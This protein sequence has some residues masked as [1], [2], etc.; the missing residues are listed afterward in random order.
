MFLNL[1]KIVTYS[2]ITTTTP[3]WVRLQEAVLVTARHSFPNTALLPVALMR[4]VTRKATRTAPTGTLVT[5]WFV[6]SDHC[7]H[8]PYNH[9]PYNHYPYNHHPC[10]H[11]L[12]NH[13]P[14]NYHP[15]NH[16][17]C[18]HYPYYIFC[19]LQLH[20]YRNWRY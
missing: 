8:H 15:Y 9:Y 3:H 11:H 4:H 6:D 12:Y 19:L 10:N 20:T 14:Y 13:H 5:L 1:F 16:H 7:N 2:F 18:N 17:P